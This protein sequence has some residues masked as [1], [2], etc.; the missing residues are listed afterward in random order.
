VNALPA[1]NELYITTPDNLIVGKV[2]EQ[3]DTSAN[4]QEKNFLLIKHSDGWQDDRCARWLKLNGYPT[5]T[6]IS[7]EG[8]ALPDVKDNS[9]TFSLNSIL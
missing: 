9:I 5:L 6:H 7:R 1:Q 3:Q 2:A 8:E 4:R